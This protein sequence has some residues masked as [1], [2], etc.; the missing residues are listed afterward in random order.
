MAGKKGRSGGARIGAGRPRRDPLAAWLGGSAGRREP[1]TVARPPDKPAPA[2]PV[3]VPVDLE[4]EVRAVWELLAPHAEAERTLTKASTL[5]FGLLCRNIVFERRLASSPLKAAGTD[6]RG[7]L[8]RVEAGLARF[9]LIPDG[10]PVV[11]LEPAKDGWEE[12]DAPR[13]RLVQSS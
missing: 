13:P 4:A 10:R 2:E 12:F 5:A 9:R 6:H 7:M 11:A 8:V 1:K 3:A